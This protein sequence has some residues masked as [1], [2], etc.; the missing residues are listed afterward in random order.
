MEALNNPAY[1]IVEEDKPKR[2]G[3]PKGSKNKPKGGDV[4]ANFVYT[5]PD[6]DTASE[7]PVITTTSWYDDS[8]PE[9]VTILLQSE[10]VPDGLEAVVSRFI[11][12][13]VSA[14]PN[15]NASVITNIGSAQPLIL[16]T[17]EPYEQVKKKFFP[18]AK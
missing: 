11:A 13:A 16:V 3:R 4:D 8:L 2:K 18:G 5:L 1:A 14:L 10:Q 6:D 17:A 12:V 15:G 7:P 9:H